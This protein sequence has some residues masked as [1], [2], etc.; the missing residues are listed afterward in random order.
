MSPR[1][2]DGIFYH[3]SNGGFPVRAIAEVDQAAFLNDGGQIFADVRRTP[4]GIDH[5]GEVQAVGL[6]MY[7]DEGEEDPARV[8]EEPV[9]AAEEG[10]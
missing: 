9:V 2:P 10:D 4:F 1:E 6:D 7:N 8:A 5:C 3:G